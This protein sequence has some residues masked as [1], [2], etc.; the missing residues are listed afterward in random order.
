M[1]ATTLKI[2]NPLLDSLYKGKPK[3]ISFAAYVREILSRFVKQNETLR[4]ASTYVEFL[5]SNPDEMEW[6]STWESADL[7]I[8]AKNKNKSRK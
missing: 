7:T 6:L 3:S 5:K 1:K 8:P 2:E 4:A